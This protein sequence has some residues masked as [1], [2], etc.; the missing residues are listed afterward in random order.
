MKDPFTQDYLHS[1]NGGV[2]TSASNPDTTLTLNW[3]RASDNYTAEADLKYFV[4]RS[5]SDNISTVQNAVDNG[6]L[7]NVGGSADINTYNVSGLNPGTTYYFNVI[8]ED[9]AGYKAAYSSLE[10]E[11]PLEP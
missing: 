6:T 5:D 10:I 3:T 2:I 7:L 4:Y 11:S 1:R 8:V 9:D